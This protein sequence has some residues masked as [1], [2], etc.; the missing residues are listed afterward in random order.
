MT[1]Q[2]EALEIA[3]KLADQAERKKGGRLMVAVVVQQR[4]DS[5]GRRIGRT[6]YPR[7]F[8]SQG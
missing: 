2:P 3:Q 5:K 6:K 7:L 1:A 4:F 8:V